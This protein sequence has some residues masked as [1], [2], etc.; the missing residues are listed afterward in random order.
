ML[1]FFAVPNWSLPDASKPRP[2]PTAAA[3]VEE[4]RPVAVAIPEILERA[5]ARVEYRGQAALDRASELLT[6]GN[7]PYVYARSPKDLPALLRTADQLITLAHQE[8]GERARVWR[9]ECGTRYAV[10]V[11]LMRPAAIRCER[12]GHTLELDPAQGSS[13][14]NV[15]EPIQGEV[16][17][18]R[19][20]L[21]DFFREAMARGWVVMVQK[22]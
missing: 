22:S 13:E 17:E 16:N 3:P 9:C 10:P 18:Y 11:S 14:S 1:T 6:Q 15:L 20:A 12:C 19:S 8:S 2:T 4:L 21:A 5:L 7:G